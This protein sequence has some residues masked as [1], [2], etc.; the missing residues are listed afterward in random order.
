VKDNSANTTGHF[1]LPLL[2]DSAVSSVESKDESALA[3]ESEGVTITD[4]NRSG[5]ESFPPE[6]RPFMLLV[7]ESV[8]LRFS[9]LALG[10][11]FI[12][13]GGITVAANGCTFVARGASLRGGSRIVWLGR[14]Y[15]EAGKQHTPLVYSICDC[16]VQPVEEGVAERCVDLGKR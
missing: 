4:R 13:A 14:S 8:V 9:P 10:T 12:L 2:A 16:F 3:A 7:L 15:C 11:R 5:F 1:W 6:S